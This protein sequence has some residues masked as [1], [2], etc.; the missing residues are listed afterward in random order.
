MSGSD[1]LL[2]AFGW[3][4]VIEGIT[5]LIAPEKW[6]RALEA[7]SHADPRAVRGA[8]GVIVAAGLL[9]I[10]AYLGHLPGGD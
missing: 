9:I 10:W 7:A 1:I 4:L 8:A 2:L 3:V 6:Q 5:P